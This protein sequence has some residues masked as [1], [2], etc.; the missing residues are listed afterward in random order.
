[1]T[2]NNNTFASINVIKKTYTHIY[3]GTKV[4][5]MPSSLKL[6]FLSNIRIKKTLPRKNALAYFAAESVAEK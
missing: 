1:M 4:I 5:K 3:T 2:L 6:G